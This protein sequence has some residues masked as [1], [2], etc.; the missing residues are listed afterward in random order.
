MVCEEQMTKKSQVNPF[1]VTVRI[2]REIMKR[3]HKPICA[4]CNKIVD[5]FD[6]DIENM[7]DLFFY[8]KV[9]C[10]GQVENFSVHKGWFL[11][12]ND[13]ELT[14]RAFESDSGMRRIDFDYSL[15]KGR[16]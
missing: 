15:L 5:A 16:S 4:K 3:K 9:R 11:V 13:F 14:G 8:F 1:T 6:L 12:A 10:H 7:N 2:V